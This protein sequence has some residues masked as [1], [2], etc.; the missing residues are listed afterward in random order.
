MGT[1]WQNRAARRRETTQAVNPLR[2][3]RQRLLD[4]AGN[5]RP[6]AVSVDANSPVDSLVNM[7]DNL[8]ANL[9]T[10]RARL[11]KYDQQLRQEEAAVDA[12]RESVR[13]S[14][15]LR[16]RA[17]VEQEARDRYDRRQAARKASRNIK[18]LFALIIAAAIAFVLYQF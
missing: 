6:V 16:A 7:V 17:Q 3:A 13:N 12:V 10:E 15:F 9:A 14:S 5:S 8:I 1:W 2:E 18:R 11:P 4:A